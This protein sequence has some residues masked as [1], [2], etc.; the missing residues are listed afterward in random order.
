MDSKTMEYAQA[1][2]NETGR[3]YLITVFGHCFMD[4]AS[5]RKMAL[6]PALGEGI[7]ATVYPNYS[8]NS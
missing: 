3:P 2:A 8:R 4:C 5:N 1:R 7:A 6:N